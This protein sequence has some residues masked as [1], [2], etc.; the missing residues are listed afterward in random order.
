MEREQEEF[1]YYFS[2][3]KNAGK[4]DI[5]IFRVAASLDEA[6]SF[7][8]PS[9]DQDDLFPEQGVSEAIDYKENLDELSPFASMC[10]KKM[11]K[12]YGALA[13]FHDLVQ[14][15]N[16][17]RPLMV[18]AGMES[19]VLTKVREKGHLLRQTEDLETYG[20]NAQTASEI[21]L[22]VDRLKQIDSG[23]SILPSSVLLSLV[24]TFDSMIGDG[25]KELLKARPDK[26]TSSD[27]T[28]TYREL[29]NIGSLDDAK[30]KFINDEVDKLL[31]GSHDD[32][33]L[34]V[35]KL[36]DTKI[37]DHYPRWANFIEVFERRNIIAHANGNYSQLYIDRCRSAGYPCDKVVVGDKASLRSKYLHKSIDTLTEFGILIWFVAWRKLDTKSEATAFSRLNMIAFGAI[38][39]FRYELAIWLLDFALHRQP[40]NADEIT[41]RMMVINLANAYKK[42]KKIDKC[43]EV[44]NAMD[45]TAT[46]DLFALALAS[47]ND[48]AEEAAKLVLNL[49]RSDKLR[50]EDF[51]DWPIFDWIR[52]EIVVAKA[53]EEGFGHPLVVNIEER[54]SLPGSEIISGDQRSEDAMGD[55]GERTDNEEARKVVH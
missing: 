19:G 29:F 13:P 30:D 44:L 32:Q 54:A 46:S 50:A 47:L 22:I 23:L 33:I 43:K 4:G 27:K 49:A 39:G 53:F 12:F 45:W 6:E 18:N 36:T 14:V 5:R 17:V 10:E 24:A 21:H 26:I 48:D 16:F 41:T 51:R 34:Y 55:V 52:S 37:R 28:V 38:K 7:V 8:E 31:R 40:R 3:R 15:A 1:V 11:E 42:T 2:V 35:E 25:I 20:L 9:E